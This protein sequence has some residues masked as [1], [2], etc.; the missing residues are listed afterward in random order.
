MAPVQEADAYY[1]AGPPLDGGSTPA[2]LAGDDTSSAGVEVGIIVAVLVVIFALVGGMFVWRARKHRRPAESV[3]D[4]D[5]DDDA[6]SAFPM[7]APARRNDEEAAAQPNGGGGDT[8]DKAGKTDDAR[9]ETSRAGSA[10][11]DDSS[12]L[13]QPGAGKP[14]AEPSPSPTWNSWVTVRRA[15]RVG[16]TYAQI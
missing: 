13:E 3:R 2:A 5:D 8:R 1:S 16:G 12:S 15:K 9:P 11:P 4:D 14:D 7:T 6:S 10:K